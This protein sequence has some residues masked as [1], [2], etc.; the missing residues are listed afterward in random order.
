MAENRV[1]NMARLLDGMSK[2][3]LEAS[4]VASPENFFYTSG[5]KIQTQTLIRDRLALGI[6]AADG[7]T[8]LVVNKNEEGQTRRYSWVTD[9]RTYIEFHESPMQIVAA[10]LE[11]KGLAKGRIGVEKKYVTADYFE[12]LQ[13]RLPHSTL[14]SCDAAFDWARMVKTSAEIEA[15]SLAARGTDESIRRALQVAK[16]GDAEYKLART[17]VDN[18]FDVGKGEFRDITWGVASGPNV[19]TTHY[20]AGER[21]ISPGDIVRIN[22]RS[23]IRGYYSHLYR[24]AVVSEPNERQ[25]SWYARS[26]E[27]HYRSIDRLRPGARACDLFHA[28]R[29]DII[30]AGIEFHSAHV[31][32]STGIALHENPRLQALDETVLEPGMVFAAEPIIRDPGHSIYHLEDLVLVTD[33]DPV[34]LSDVANTEQLIMIG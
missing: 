14:A 7:S 19:L 4:V 23:A 16:P 12:D 5:L 17:M 20:W 31:G 15:L 2:A 24:M 29:Q 30:D 3:G 1:T 13:S 6:V 32:H 11:E 27:I 28:A 26:R 9:V 21:E 10:V 22:L 8:T 25:K 34:L 33:K 18:L